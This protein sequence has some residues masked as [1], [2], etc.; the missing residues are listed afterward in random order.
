MD[1]FIATLVQFFGNLIIIT[2]GLLVTLLWLGIIL[3]GIDELISA[4]TDDKEEDDGDA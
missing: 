1:I 4:W 3:V 2:A